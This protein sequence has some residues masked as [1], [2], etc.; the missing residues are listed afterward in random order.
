MKVHMKRQHKIEIEE[1]SENKHEYFTNYLES[2]IEEP[3]ENK[4]EYFDNNFESYLTFL[5][6]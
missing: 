2:E 5:R 6:K 1:P 3:L 4:H